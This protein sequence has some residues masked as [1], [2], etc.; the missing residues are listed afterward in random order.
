[1]FVAGL[2]ALAL[3][4]CSDDVGREAARGQMSADQDW[5][6]YGGVNADRFSPLTQ[7]TPEN[8]AGLSEVWRF[9]AGS[10]GL[11][12]S[13]L[14]VGQVLYGYTVTQAVFALDASTGRSLW[15]FNSGAEGRQP[16][17]GLTYWREASEQRLFAGVMHEL[18]ALD[19]R[20]GAPIRSFGDNGKID[21]RR[22]LNDQDA[23]NVAYLTSPGVIYRDLIIVGF[24][25]AETAPA[26][27]GAVRAYDVR[28]GEMRWIFRMI[29]RPGEAGHDTW[30]ADAWKAAGG[31]NAWAGAVVDPKNGIVFVPT[32]SAVNDFYGA[33]RIGDNLFANSLVALDASTGKRLWHFQGVHH[34]IWDR[35]FPSPPVLL[36]VEREG[37][38]I[39][40]VAQTSKQGYVFVFERRTGKPLF[41]I[42]ERAVPAGDTP[43]ERTA[44]TQPFPLAPAPFARQQLTQD[45]LTQRTPQANAAAREA[46]AKFHNEGPFT[47]LKAGQ[48]TV[49]FPGFDGGAEWGGPAVDPRRGVLYVNANDIAWTGGLIKADTALAA[50]ADFYQSQCAVCHG[51]DRK[52]SPPEFPSLVGIGSRMNA[53]EILTIVYQGR[54]RMPAFPNISGDAAA[55]LADYL[56]HEGKPDGDKQEIVSSSSRATPPYRFTGYKK[57]LDADGYPAV[58][59]PWGT[60]SAIDLNDGHY[61]WKV[62]LGEYPAL[63]AQGARETGS[64]NYGGP[65]VTAGGVLFIGATIYDR[66]FRAFDAASGVRL[67]ETTLPFAGNATPVTYMID[68]RQYVV[69]ATSGARDR[70]GPQGSAYVAFALP[71]VVPTGD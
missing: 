23:T 2:V 41:P 67:W 21:L 16:A 50:S 61:L 35:D 54:E 39:E 11:Q 44:P 20:T 47:P 22:G 7:L 46:F 59:P 52:G 28:T 8:V 26:A 18:W 56:N 30:P 63:V 58:A 12:T 4:G 42:E 48:Q 71:G 19:P 17:R 64:E 37:R 29:P 6:V 34:D 5:P 51:V 24:R 57:F 38:R 10:G 62:P 43:G 40:A 60:L 25:T 9:D 65:I 27:P 70:A 14:V 55:A 68:G 1:L 45:M 66:K 13:P 15:T 49:V 36:T 69:I 33:D 32:G 3:A 31:A 53:Q